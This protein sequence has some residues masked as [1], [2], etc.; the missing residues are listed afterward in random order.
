[1]SQVRN[2]L[3][4]YEN[5][6]EYNSA[7]FPAKVKRR[8]TQLFQGRFNAWLTRR[9]PAA[10]QHQLTSR[11][12]FIMPT[13]FGFAYLF[14]VLLLFLLATNYQNNIIMLFS[15][16]MASLFI[17]AMMTSFF[18]LSGL[19]IKAQDKSRG[20]VDQ[21]VNFV[22]TTTSKQ[23][24]FDL[25][26]SFDL[27]NTV[28]L[29]LCSP[30]NN[31]VKVPYL[32]KTRGRFS[33]GRLKLSSEYCF[34][35]FITWTR[36]DFQCQAVVYP[37]IKAINGAL[38]AMSADA[39]SNENVTSSNKGNDDFYELKNYVLGEPLSRIAWKQLAKGQGKFTKHYQ[40]NQG[41]LCWLNLQDM[42]AND[43]ESKLQLLCYIILEYSKTA[44]Q[45]GLN[46]GTVKIP[47]ND[48]LQHMHECLTALTDLSVRS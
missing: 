5:K 17:T 33:P 31:T 34:G 35:L 46:L 19:I 16:L 22:V 28:Q 13:R 15:Y 9:I 48:G 42:P 45:F 39:D 10:E 7:S 11:N 30:G 8:I 23:R 26:F 12:I 36:L 6:D 2:N 40:Q 21:P 44:Q 18:N 37:K 4:G 41:N 32:G 1:M 14:F 47:P 25:N 27:Q 38:P 24:R 29:P 3:M 43:I 20:H